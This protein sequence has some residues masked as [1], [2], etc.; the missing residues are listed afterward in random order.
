V[1]QRSVLFLA[2]IA[3]TAAMTSA[4]SAGGCGWGWGG[5]SGCGWSGWNGCG[6]CVAGYYTNGFVVRDASPYYVV[7]Q[8]PVFSGP[9]IVTYPVY[10]ARSYPYVG[11]CGYGYGGCFGVSYT[12]PVGYFDDYRYRDDYGVRPSRAPRVVYFNDRGPKNPSYRLKRYPHL[13]PLPPK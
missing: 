9:A 3:A 6:G 11:G 8:G 4:A 1:R 5:W 2:I 12:R 10:Q 13:H 7:N